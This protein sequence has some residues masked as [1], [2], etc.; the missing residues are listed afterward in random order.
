MR[1][2]SNLGRLF[3]AMLPWH[4]AVLAEQLAGEVAR[5]CRANLGQLVHHRTSDMSIAETRGYVRA[6]SAGYVADEVNHILCQRHVK[7][8][9]RKR[10][11]DMAVDQLVGMVVRD[12][13]CE[14][15][16]GRARSMAA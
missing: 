10:I 15:V 5:E 4:N 9:L 13:L 7:P 8:A 11:A 1:L 12:V 14:D 6:Q 16:S 3:R 2:T